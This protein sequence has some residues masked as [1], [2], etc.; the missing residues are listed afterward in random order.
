MLSIIIPTKNRS[1]YLIDLVNS[2]DKQI[3]SPL[4]IIIIDQSKKFNSDISLKKDY[5]K[6]IHNT[7]ISNLSDAKNYG[8]NY[9]SGEYI[10]FFDDDIVLKENFID[11]LD[12]IL[13]K[14]PIGVSGVEERTFINNYYIYIFKLISYRGMFKDDRIIYKKSLLDYKE[15]NKIFGG[16]SF[17]RA[18]IFKKVKFRPNSPLFI[19]EDTDFS[20]I[21][22]SKFNE[23]FMIN[24]K[25]NYIHF[26]E[27]PNVSDTSATNEILEKKILSNLISYKYLHLFHKKN[28]YDELSLIWIFCCHFPYLLFLSLKRF[29]INFTLLFFKSIFYSIKKK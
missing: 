15:S 24:S 29:N 20:L 25:M 17:F 23:K 3:K 18:E 9:A 4:E 21:V 16:C 22:R 28:L 27:T 1:K 19:N 14:N 5:I 26:T 10:G 8:L 13:K 11:E 2:I 6:Y 7:N 12:L